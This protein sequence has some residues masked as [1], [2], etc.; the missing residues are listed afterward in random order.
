V[1]STVQDRAAV[2]EACHRLTWAFDHGEWDVVRPHLGDPVTF[3]VSDFTGKGPS[4]LTPREFEKMV[5][6]WDSGGP[7][8]MQH[9]AGNA[10]VDWRAGG[11]ATVRMY[12]RY[13]DVSSSNLGVIN[14]VSGTYRFELFHDDNVWRI[15]GLTVRQLWSGTLGGHLQVQSA[16]SK[17]RGQ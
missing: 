9:L 4:V 7:V 17:S 6:D 1:T 8:V 11:T 2:I 10:I 13:M 12:V 3:D 15:A 16:T 5:R 14:M